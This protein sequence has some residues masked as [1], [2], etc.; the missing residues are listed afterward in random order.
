MNGQ[1]RGTE[2]ARCYIMEQDYAKG[3]QSKQYN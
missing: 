1:I 2:S 3:Y